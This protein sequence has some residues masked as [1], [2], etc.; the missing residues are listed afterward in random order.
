MRIIFTPG[1][2][3]LAL[4]WLLLLLGSLPAL[5]QTPPGNALNFD[6]V[7]DYIVTSSSTGY[8][9]YTVEAWVRTTNAATGDGGTIVSNYPNFM[10]GMYGGKA[11]FRSYNTANTSYELVSTT[12]INDGKWHHV[13][14]VMGGG[15]NYNM[16]LYV[17]GVAE[18]SR[19][20][21][22][23]N[24]SSTYVGCLQGNQDLWQGSIDEVRIWD[25]AHSAAEIKTFFNNPV[26]PTEAGLLMNYTFDRGTAGGNNAGQTTEPNPVP[27]RCGGCSTFV[28][29]LYNFA[30]S[31]STSNLVESY[32]L[33][34]PTGLAATSSA[35]GTS[36]NVSWTAPPVGTVSNYVLDVSTTA[37]FSA[38]VTTLTPA[39]SASSS[40]VPGRTVN[41]LY[42]LRLKTDKASVTGQSA[43]SRDVFNLRTA[44]GLTPPGNA[45]AF[46]GSD[47]YVALL[48]TTPV[49]TGN[50]TYTLEA[51]IKPNAMGVYGI[52]GWGNWGVGNQVNALRL[53]PTGIINYWWGPDL[54]VT[55][56]DLSGHWHHVAAT[57]D[58]TTRTIFLDG[59]AVGSDT[60][61]SHTVPSPSNLRIGSTNNGEYFNGSIDEVRIWN[62]ARSAAQMKAAYTSWPAL[63]Q[64]GLVAAYDF[65][66]GTAGGANSGQATLPDRTTNYQDG[67]L[68]NFSLASG[69]TTSNWVESYALVVP[70]LA[71]ATAVTTAGFTANWTAPLVGTVTGY[72]LDYSLSPTFATVAGTVSPAAGAT[73]QAVSGLL[74]NRN[75]YYHLRADK[76]SGA[77]AGQGAYASGTVRTASAL[78]PPG[79]ALAFDGSDD[80]VAV[81]AAPG[82]NNLGK[83]SFTL[84]SWVYSTNLG[85]V[86]SIIRKGGDYNLVLQ[87]GGLLLAEVWPGGM[88]TSTRP[89]AQATAAILQ[90]RWTHVAA[91]WDGTALRLYVNG[92]AAPL[93]ANSSPVTTS[94]SLQIGRSTVFNQPFNGRLDEVRIYNA[95]L[96]PAQILADMTSTSATVPASLLLYYN[97][98]QGTAYGNNAGAT[99]LTDQSPTL[100]DGT[101][102]N[103]AL[104]SGNTTSNWVESYA[105]VVPAL[106]AATANAATSFVAT[107][108]APAIGTVS[109]YVLDVATGRDFALL[110][111]GSPFAVAGTSQTVTGLDPAQ[112]Y[113][114]RVRADKTSVTGQGAYSATGVRAPFTPMTPPGNALALDGSDDYVTGNNPQL[115]QGNAARTLEAWVLTTQ[116]TNGVIVNYGTASSNLRSGI[117]VI[118]GKAYYVGEGNDL[119]GTKV[120]NDGHWHHVA[121][122]Y[123]GTSLKLYVDGVLD[124]SNTPAAFNTT[125]FDWNIGKR[126]PPLTLNEQFNG[127]LDEV[128]IYSTALTPAQVLADMTSTSPAVPASLVAYYNFDQGAASGNNTGYTTLT[129]QSANAS[130]GT[131]TN[132]N[133]GSGNTTSNWVE[134]YALLQPTG[135]TASASTGTGFT[136]S[137]TAPLLNGAAPA[138]GE[139]EAYVLD[140]SASSTFASGGASFPVSGYGSTSVAATGLTNGTNYYLRVRAEKA[141]VT[142]QGDYSP[143]ISTHTI[144]TDALLTNLTASAGQMSPVFA[145]ATL[146]YTLYV[147]TGTSTYTL[148]PTASNAYTNITVNGTAVTSGAA[149]GALSVGSTATVVLTSEDGSA[150][151]TYTVQAV[152]AP[153]YFR[154]VATGNWGD[155]ATW[156]ASYDGSTGWAA[157]PVAPS[158]SLMGTVNV[159]NG[160][161]VTVAAATST[162]T[163]TVESG[164]VLNTLAG[165]TLTVPTGATMTVNAGGVL[166][167]GRLTGTDAVTGA[168]LN[169][170]TISVAGANALL[171]NGTL[172]LNTGSTLP[173]NQGINTATTTVGSGARLVQYATTTPCTY[174][175]ATWGAGATL[176]LAG[177]IMNQFFAWTFNQTLQNLE[178]N[179]TGL[180][181]GIAAS[182]QPYLLT[183]ANN[184]PVA[185]TLT[186]RSTGLGTLRLYNGSSGTATLTLGSVDGSGNRSGG[187]V[188]L[189]GTNV[190]GSYGGV[191]T[192]GGTTINVLGSFQL[193]GNST[194]AAAQASGTALNSIRT[195]VLTIAGDVSVA[196]GATFNVL[197]DLN[198]TFLYSG[199]LVMV[200]GNFNNAGTVS[201]GNTASATPKL[202]FGKAGV[203]TFSSPGTVTGKVNVQV[204]TGSTLDL[205]TSSFAGTGTFTTQA[206]TGLRLGSPDGISATG[207][208]TGNVQVTG[209]RSFATNTSFE[210]N[211]TAAQVTGTGF[212]A[213]VNTS[214]TL[215]FN[216][217]TG[218]T[219][220]QA[221]TA[222]GTLSLKQ[223]AVT[224]TA[225]NLL[226][227]GSN[228]TVTGTLDATATNTGVIVGPFKRWIAA[229]T[230]PR[231]FPVGTPTQLR[232]ATI[233]FTTAPTAGGSL[234]A[235]FIVLPSGNQGLPLAENGITINKAS[236]SGYWRVAAGD[237]LAGGTYTPTFTFTGVLGVLDYT[238][239]VLLKRAD[240]SADWALVGAPVPTRGSNAAPVLSRTGVSGFSDFTA[241]GDFNV[242][243][244]PVTLVDFTARTQGDA[245]ALSWTTA[246]EKN[247]KSFEVE[248][249]ADGTTF[250]RIGTVAAAGSSSP[251]VYELLDG[252]L[253]TGAAVLYY[254]LKQVDLNGTFSY[255]PVRTVALTRAAAGLSLYPNPASHGAATLTGALPGAVVTVF[256]ALGRPVT[257]GTADAA[258]TAALVLPA[259]L[260][261]GVYVVRVGAKALRLTVE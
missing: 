20:G 66:A 210:F 167:I 224:S 33:M 218:V 240:P 6:G 77:V 250:A 188:Q 237:G 195:G 172:V 117:L 92:V 36:L 35:S 10:V 83:G 166:S 158:G 200:N 15:I 141:S 146:A 56:P 71:A 228:T 227:L 171:V 99:T 189:A 67:T 55:T 186:V 95:A 258:G 238:Q 48:N 246:S 124:I 217:P 143:V 110:V 242:N 79:N 49:P 7:N 174:P 62:V 253:P 170:G 109:N 220:S 137:W 157:A 69:N 216:N 132:F 100:A 168:S 23:T 28:G 163:T 219:L 125:G 235:E 123:D 97:F 154:S 196:S 84:E 27:R 203:Q 180:P 197:S 81:S 251:H 182:P 164:G 14:A 209:T 128:R 104:S 72:V 112:T 30:L 202:V 243:P 231:T 165:Q 87:Q 70:T 43:Y 107:W 13:A 261:A 94:E 233:D 160:H 32:A 46:D 21:G 149:S 136:A 208:A 230:G 207:T 9:N 93:S 126:I 82:L 145:T 206:G 155:P 5:A 129:D 57:F 162:K 204:N 148:T 29:T 116:T 161:T 40:V 201:S 106:T 236:A 98:D 211:G 229:T 34:Q 19:T 177:G 121:A 193:N 147:P 25:V 248:R 244:L 260:P 169:L 249:S 191:N 8:F 103:F 4:A 114:Y 118:G 53:S 54:V 133:L 111:A 213:I 1:F 38:G 63:P 247:S 86:N 73:S 78:T 59:V 241:G 176:E 119:S 75:Y 61:G 22:Y 41:T 3:R 150:T 51:W 17:D 198:P 50:S 205:G 226:T 44:S 68:N 26:L 2:P 45:L 18:G 256:D 221:L 113:Y 60:P 175:T 159:R 91:T 140:V 42:Y 11:R 127:R 181:A 199:G 96:T 88:G 139:V 37:D 47:D 58:G 245:V 131:L 90:N 254:R 214:S 153:A 173:A 16:T 130:Y 156:E 74:P 101:L 89:Y 183:G 187:Y 222:T 257:V 138:A 39:G 152:V 215:T 255:S 234:T 65:D 76:T 252:Q 80:Y 212:P 120:I 31:G 232:P 108:T 52:I 223:G 225:A 24:F 184:A 135:L 179:L 142:G 144:G 64:A 194:F 85:A 151:R 190:I 259:G 102:T 12:L 134:S 122:T 239:L 115:P 185:G 192:T 178:V 105:L